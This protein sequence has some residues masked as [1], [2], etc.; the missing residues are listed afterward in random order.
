M[1]NRKGFTL[2]E[3]LSVIIIIGVILLIAF[4]AVNSYIDKANRGSYVSSV[5][6]YMETI[7]SEY[8]M[9]DYGDLIEDGELMI[10]PIEN[11]KLEKGD[12]K[13]PYAPFDFARSYVYV[14]PER[15]G[16]Q[17]YSNIMD[18]AG[19]GVIGKTMN[20]LSRDVVEEELDPD[21]IFPWSSYKSGTNSFVFK[22]TEYSICEVRDIDTVEKVVSEAILVMC[23]V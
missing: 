13:S 22:N 5:Q 15:N 17:F 20:E 6:A 1:K 9:G 21:I 23:E 8:E 3:V 14:V 7:K 19:V 18:E 4:P 16:Y 11:I 2:I 12:E 10:V